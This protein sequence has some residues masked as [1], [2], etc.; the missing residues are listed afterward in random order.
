VHHDGGATTVDVNQQQN[1]ATWVLLGVFDL[2]PGANPRVVLSNIANGSVR[3]DAIR[4]VRQVTAETELVVDNTDAGTS[5]AGTWSTG[6]SYDAGDYYGSNYIAAISGGGADS[7]TWPAEVAA[8]GRYQIFARWTSN[9]GRNTAAE[10]TVHHS[11]GATAV[12]ANQQQNASIWVSLGVYQLAPSQNHR[13]VLTDAGTGSVAADAIRVVPVE[14]GT[15]PVYADA[16]RFVAND[17]ED[18]LYVH[19][20]HLGSPQKLTD[21]AGDVVWDAQFTPFGEPDAITGAANDNRRF[22]GQYFDAES[23]FHYNWFRDYDPVLGRYVQA[24]PIGLS[25]ADQPNL[26]TYSSENPIGEID[27]DGRQPQVVAP[28][29]LGIPAYVGHLIGRAL[30]GQMLIYETI[31]GPLLDPSLSGMMSESEAQAE[32]DQADESARGSTALVP[33]MCQP[34]CPPCKTVTGKVVPLGTFGHHG[35]DNENRWDIVQ[36]GIR[37]PHLNV[38][39]ANQIPANHPVPKMRCNCFWSE[40]GTFPPNELPF[41]NYMWMEPFDNSG[42]PL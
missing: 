19:S 32:A 5:Q 15:V 33:F 9:T 23:G 10:Y 13:V 34:G 16:I 17:A 20:D 22:P 18:V 35:I 21:L 4:V 37:G 31:Y 11:G 26:Y 24:D 6:T 40:V 7:F 41:G 25:L 29:V 28:V 30:Q 27:R 14:Y 8:A 2:T 3:A 36:H 42:G 39:K 38:Y 12:T 1:R